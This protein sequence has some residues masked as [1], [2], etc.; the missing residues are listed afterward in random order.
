M[1]RMQISLAA[2]S[3]VGAGYGTVGVKGGNNLHGG[4]IPDTGVGVADACADKQ[5]RRCRQSF[6]AMRRKR[7]NNAHS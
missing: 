2:E 3:T 7:G 6:S 5:R 1:L 4:E